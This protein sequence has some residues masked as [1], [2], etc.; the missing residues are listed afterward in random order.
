VTAESAQVDVDS[1]IATT[2]G[3]WSVALT[4]SYR[5]LYFGIKLKTTYTDVPTVS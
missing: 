5:A 2:D 1:E 3:V 4:P